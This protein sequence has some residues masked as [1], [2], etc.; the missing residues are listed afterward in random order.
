[1]TEEQLSQIAEYAKRIQP[2]YAMLNWQW[3]NYEDSIARVPNEKHI[4]DC[5]VELITKCETRIESGGL[6]AERD[7]AYMSYGLI[8]RCEFKLP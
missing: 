1:M 4:A 2:I 3:D 5:L 7:E 8:N 6:F